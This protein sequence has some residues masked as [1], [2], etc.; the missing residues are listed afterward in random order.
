MFV[1]FFFNFMVLKNKKYPVDNEKLAYKN[2]YGN[3]REMKSYMIGLA[4]SQFLWPTHYAMYSF[5][6]EKI[7]N[8]KFRKFR[9]LFS[10]I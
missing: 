9:K 5:F 4:I 8:I 3:I 10:E 1:E 2:V 7:E 6:I